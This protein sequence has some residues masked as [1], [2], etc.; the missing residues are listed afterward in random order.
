MS[1]KPK[2]IYEYRGEQFSSAELYQIACR[3]FGCN[4]IYKSFCNRLS[5]WDSVERVVEYFPLSK[6]ARGYTK[7]PPAHKYKQEVNMDL[8]SLQ[9]ED[10]KVPSMQKLAVHMLR[11]AYIDLRY[12][13]HQARESAVNWLKDEQE[14]V[15]WASAFPSD[16]SSYYKRQA[17]RLLTQVQQGEL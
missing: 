10:V 14:V 1:K 13:E 6:K 4:I 12:G 8:P 9:V 11:A 16:S 17:H 2:G 7:A 15:R 3:D 5:T